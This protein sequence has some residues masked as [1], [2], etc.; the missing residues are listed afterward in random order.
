MPDCVDT[1]IV[2]GGLAGACAAL[3]LSRHEQVCL[4][5]AHGPAT[6]AS[7]IPA[8]LVTPLIALRARPAWRVAEAMAA[9]Q[10]LLSLAGAAALFTPSGVLRPARD[11]EQRRYFQQSAQRWPD[12]GCWWPAPMVHEHYP[13][14]RA[15]EGALC[16]QRGGVIPIPPLV[17]ALLHTARQHGAQVH[18][19][20]RVTDWGEVPNRAYVDATTAGQHT[21][22]FARRVLLCPGNGFTEHPELQRLDLHPIKG[23]VIVLAPP[24]DLPGLPPLSGTCYLAPAAGKLVIGS[25][26]EHTFTHL[27][28]SPEH[29]TRLRQ[30]A[31]KMVPALKDQPVLEEVVRVRATVPHVRLPMLGPLPGRTRLWVFTGLGSKGLLMAPMLARAL[32]GWFQHPDT[33]PAEIAVRLR[34]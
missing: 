32:T 10:E 18:P 8:G 4:L 1:L 22:L 19:H 33:I 7:G 28:P 23:Q 5:E 24:A 3:Y 6:G 30:A 26:Y 20:A 17:D 27:A 14:V 9:L 31:A 16:I 13:F 12:E 29:T 11:A 15:S 2:G 34:P 21:R 25:S